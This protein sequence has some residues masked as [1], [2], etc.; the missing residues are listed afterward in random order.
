MP[1]NWTPIWTLIDPVSCVSCVSSWYWV[2]AAETHETVQWA[3]GMRYH[4]NHSILWGKRGSRTRCCGP[5]PIAHGREPLW[6]PL[7][8]A[9][10]GGRSV[11]NRACGTYSI[12]WRAGTMPRC[13]LR[14]ITVMCVGTPPGSERLAMLGVDPAEPDE[15]RL[16]KVTLSAGRRPRRIIH[17]LIS[18][19]LGASIRSRMRSMPLTNTRNSSPLKSSNSSRPMAR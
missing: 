10:L 11:P 7:S 16:Q 12:P 1:D 6:E 2:N 18:E 17:R 3:S 19:S 15:L 9:H 5:H 4:F 13:G 14:R 8:C